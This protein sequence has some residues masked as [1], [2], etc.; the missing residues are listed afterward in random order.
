MYIDDT[1]DVDNDTEMHKTK[2]GNEEDNSYKAQAIKTDSMPTR[3]HTVSNPAASPG[4]DFVW[5]P[6]PD[7][8]LHSVPSP[9]NCSVP[10]ARIQATHCSRR[11]MPVTYLQHD[12][13]PMTFVTSQMRTRSPP[14]DDSDGEQVQDDRDLEQ[15]EEDATLC[16]CF[17]CPNKTVPQRVQQLLDLAAEDE[18]EDPEVDDEE[19]DRKPR[20]TKVD[21][22]DDREHVNDLV[23]RI[24][25]VDALR[26]EAKHYNTVT[27]AAYYEA[28]AAAANYGS[29]DDENGKDKIPVIPGTWVNAGI[30]EHTRKETLIGYAPVKIQQQLSI[31]LTHG[32]SSAA[33]P[34]RMR[35]IFEQS[36]T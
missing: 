24:P 28:A 12:F 6:R 11:D 32:T 18:D 34:D 2:S 22:V 27:L 1:A 20:Q 3:R 30:G 31:E 25:R 35:P 21:F 13:T 9:D 10:D 15:E 26:H 23:I 16:R 5:I 36:R 19:E 17:S 4:T 33:E 29:G 8:S 14:D 7:S